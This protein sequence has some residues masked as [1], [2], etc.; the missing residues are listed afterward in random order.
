MVETT[1]LESATRTV[2][3]F[4]LTRDL[5]QSLEE[6]TFGLWVSGEVG[7]V[8]RPQSGHVYFT[9]KD[10][11]K[12]AVISSVLYRR[13]ALRFGRYVV[14][15]ARVVVRGRASLYPPRGALQWIGDVVRPA[16]QGALLEALAK[17]R[18]KLVREG[19]TAPER[20]RPLP[21]Q[22]RVI[23]VVTSRDG[24]AFAD[25]VT[26]AR[27]RGRVRILLAPALVQG[28]DAPESILW[29]LD[30]IERVRDLDALIVGRGGGSQEDLMAFNDEAVVRRIAACRVPVVSAVGHE[31]DISL[32][33][34]VADVRA[35]TPSQAAELLVPDSAHRLRELGRAQRQL[36]HATLARLSR[37]QGRID[38][39]LRRLGDPRGLLITCEQEKEELGRRM[40]RSVLRSLSKNKQA[41][42]LLE[43]RLD[44]GHPRIALGRARARLSPRARDLAVHMHAQLAAR[45]AR[46]AEVR[47]ALV[48]LSPLSVLERGYALVLDASGGVVRAA[49]AV[50]SGQDVTVR[51]HRGR[52][53]ARVTSTSPAVDAEAT[54]E[55]ESSG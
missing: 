41:L 22:P 31:I 28:D 44:A 1:P 4:E 5:K 23:G 36:G 26:V 33:D 25:I 40:E 6:M 30:L 15:G 50:A 38:K 34:L 47:R 49:T 52:F 18:E 17:L 7:Q 42:S 55:E 12:D 32:T 24:A 19:L 39:L 54:F 45:Q 29:A 3:V 37:E 48:A 13:E 20:K 46:L 9:L 10:E 27:R 51:V 53:G 16:G 14:P 11:E 35:A 43:R 21:E 8:T 2:T